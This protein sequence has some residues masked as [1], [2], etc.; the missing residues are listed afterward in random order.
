MA[1]GGRFRRNSFQQMQDTCSP[2]SAFSVS[3]VFEKAG[4]PSSSPPPSAGSRETGL[5]NGRR[6]GQEGRGKGRRYKTK[7]TNAYKNP[8][9]S[10]RINFDRERKA[11][12][13]GSRISRDPRVSFSLPFFFFSSQ[14]KGSHARTFRR[15]RARN[16]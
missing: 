9:K 11:K 12:R 10:K 5:Q 7:E 1:C 4:G 16:I 14:R 6:G 8:V 3:R 15:R 2:L 13:G